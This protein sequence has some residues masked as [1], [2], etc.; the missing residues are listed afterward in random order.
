[1]V[2]IPSFLAQFDD[3]PVDS[4]RIVNPP[5]DPSSFHPAH[6][7]GYCVRFAKKVPRQL[8]ARALAAQSSKH[9]DR[10]H[11]LPAD[12]VATALLLGNP[13]DGTMNEVELLCH[14]LVDVGVLNQSH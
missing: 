13:E 3:D 9:E 6:E 8:A 4:I 12:A 1:M 2:H 10:G 11:L 7:L 14:F 5:E